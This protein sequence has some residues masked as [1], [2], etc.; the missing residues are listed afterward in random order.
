MIPYHPDPGDH[1]LGER[2]DHRLL[3]AG[4]YGRLS[5]HRMAAEDHAQ[6][7]IARAEQDRRLAEAGVH[8]PGMAALVAILREATSVVLIRVGERLRGAPQPAPAPASEEASVA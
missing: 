3:T 8:P 7:W 6:A 1:A 4:D 2:R 5:G